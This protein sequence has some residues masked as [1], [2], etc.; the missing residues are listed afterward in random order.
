MILVCFKMLSKL[1]RNQENKIK[2]Y[3][4]IGKNLFFNS[5]QI[6]LNSSFFFKFTFCFLKI[7]QYFRKTK[8]LHTFFTLPNELNFSRIQKYVNIGKIHFFEN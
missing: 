3:I 1:K 8:D 5:V 2:K 4:N 7:F 6:S